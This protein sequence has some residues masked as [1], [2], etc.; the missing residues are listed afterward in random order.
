M[1]G[2]QSPRRFGA[3]TGGSVVVAVLVLTVVAAT[4]LLAAHRAPASAAAANPSA[5]PS[6]MS[7]APVTSDSPTPALSPEPV[8][9][10][11][12]AW[13]RAGVLVVDADTGR[14]YVY[15]AGRLRPPA[16]AV[17]ADL[18]LGT[19][20]PHRVTVAHATILAASPGPAIGIKA[21][22]ALPAATTMVGGDV[23]ICS[24]TRRPTASIVFPSAAG[25][26]DAT[27]LVGYIGLSGGDGLNTSSIVV[28]NRGADYLVWNRTR[29]LISNPAAVFSAYKWAGV[30]AAAV[31]DDVLE[32]L[33]VGAVISPTALTLRPPK[34]LRL[35]LP[36]TLCIS[37]DQSG[38]VT[39]TTIN[40]VESAGTAVFVLPANAAVLIKA[41]SAA[42]T[43]DLVT[44]TG[45]YYPIT[46][47]QAALDSLGYGRAPVLVM[48]KSVLGVLIA[49]PTLSRQAAL[50]D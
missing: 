41:A 12:S 16:N 17:S 13:Q 23:A 50:A 32:T 7:S 37:L 31:P 34:P 10:A 44:A 27:G 15:V 46:G 26:V 33:P 45:I 36:A 8:S 19:P 3:A 35:A 29:H 24:V 1:G 28:S 49:G 4:A 39:H 40:P 42:S 6:L 18:I 9:T 25:G 22:P 47:G 43:I 14:S 38:T 20:T 30:V 5:S 11:A 21:A 2:R 48:P